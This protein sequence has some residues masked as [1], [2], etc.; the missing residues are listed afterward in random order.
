MVEHGHDKQPSAS[1]LISGIHMEL[2]I[3]H[4]NPTSHFPNLTFSLCE[5][6]N[7][8]YFLLRSEDSIT[9]SFMYLDGTNPR[10]SLAERGILLDSYYNPGPCI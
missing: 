9:L 1:N 7:S 6:K 4:D 2:A 8:S 3:R 5:T 10:L